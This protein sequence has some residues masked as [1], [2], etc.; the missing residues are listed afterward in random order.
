MGIIKIFFIIK[1]MV[2]KTQ[3]E[4][5]DEPFHLRSILFK[6]WQLT[7]QMG[8]AAWKDIFLHKRSDARRRFHITKFQET[9][10]NIDCF[11][12]YNG[13]NISWNLF[14]H[15]LFLAQDITYI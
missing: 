14:S 6:S 11:G 10:F 1:Y 12:T 13:H 4:M 5:G 8:M 9:W 2:A 15:F 7:I 3:K